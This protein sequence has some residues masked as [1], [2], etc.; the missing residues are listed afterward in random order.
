MAARLLEEGRRAIARLHP[1]RIGE[2]PPLPGHADLGAD[3]PWAV[4]H[5]GR[6]GV[7]QAVDVPGLVR[8]AG[9]ADCVVVAARAVGDY[10]TPGQVLLRVH[11]G[12]AARAGRLSRGIAVGAERT[13][14]LDAMYS[15]RILA[16]IAIRALSP[17]V[18][19]PTT[20]VQV[21]KR[22]HE[23]LEDLAGRDLGGAL[24]ADPAGRPRLVLPAPGWDDYLTVGL[25]EIVRFGAGSPQ[26]ARALRAVLGT[27]RDTVPAHRRAAVDQ[28]LA[29]LD[30]A[31]A[32]DYPGPLARA[33]ARKPDRQGFG[34]HSEN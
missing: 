1:H 17:A 9:R 8:E 18:N 23:L 25:A 12:D 32:Q 31:V 6:G 16:D 3:A 19:D 13:I 15:F 28:R 33:E 2:A 29:V 26:V 24:H 5:T 4:R 30:E 27:L 22:I 10:V 14:E 20:A 21:L 7:I 34:P 11:G